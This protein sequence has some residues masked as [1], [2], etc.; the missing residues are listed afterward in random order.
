[1]SDSSRQTKKIIITSI[2]LCLTDP[3]FKKNIEKLL[4]HNNNVCKKIAE[5]EKKKEKL[6]FEFRMFDSS[7][8][9]TEEKKD[10]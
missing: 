3:D 5:L 6:V 9:K 7:N 2:P 8:E 10:E 1:M 4:D